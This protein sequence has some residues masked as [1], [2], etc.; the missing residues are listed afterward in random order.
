MSNFA[1]LTIIIIS[2]IYLIISNFLVY[3]VIQLKNKNKN[4]RILLQK[5]KFAKGKNIETTEKSSL[6]SS[7]LDNNNLLTIEYQNAIAILAELAINCLNLQELMQK[8]TEIIANTL[9]IEF[10]Q[11]L[12]LLPNKSAFLLKYGVGWS[13]EIIGFARINNHNNEANYTINNQNPVIMEDLLIETRFK[14]SP[15]LHNYKIVSGVSLTIP[16][17]EEIF[18]MLAVYSLQKR[19]FNS[20]EINFLEHINKIL[21]ATIKRYEEQEKLF[22]LERAIDTSNSGILIS[23]AND[24]QNKIIYVNSGFKKITGYSKKEILGKNCNFLQLEDKK[25]PQISE[26]K[27]AILEG[28]EIETILRNYRKDGTMFW[29]KLHIAPV[30]NSE[31]ILTHFIGIQTDISAQINAELKLKEKNRIL[32]TFT[33]NLQS[34]NHI[35]LTNSETEYILDNFL[36]KGCEI[37]GM[38]TGII[39]EVINDTYLIHSC[40]S[41]HDNNVFPA[42]E[43]KLK[44]TFCYDVI[45]QKRTIGY[46]NISGNFKINPPLFSVDFQ[47][48]S[49]LGT[50]IFIKNKIY[51]TL[52]FFSTFPQKEIPSYQYELIEV[53]A[54]FIEYTIHT[55]EIELEKEQINNALQENQERLDSIFI[56]LEDVI[57]SLHLETL[58]VLYIN[59]TAEKLYECGLINFYNQRCYWLKVIHPE[60]EEWVKESYATLLNIS[61]FNSN[62]NNHDLEYRILLPNGE[63]KYVRDRAHIVYDLNKKPIR[64]DGIITE[65]TNRKKAQNALQKSEEQFRLTFQLAPIGMIITSLDGYI[66]EVNQ[67][68]CDSLKYHSSELI[69]KNYSWFIHPDDLTSD[70]LLKQKILSGEINTYEQEKRYL[71]KDGTI[72]YGIL[73][74]TV[75]QDSNQQPKQFIKQILDISERKKVEDQLLHDALYDKLTG[76]A[77]RILFIDRLNQSLNRYQT[78]NNKFCAVLFLDLDQFKRTNESLGH[79][80]GDQL[81][82]V[83]AQKIKTCL[84]PN[85]TLARLGGDEFSILLNDLK[86]QSE[87]IEIAEQI[88]IVCRSPFLIQGY[89]IFSSV[90]I[91]IAFSSL[92]YNN[93]ED[94]LRDADL[95]MY[96]AKNL[97][98]NCYHIFDKNMHSSL[99]KR[100]EI[101]SLLRKAIE[102][103]EFTLYY[104][105]IICLST[106]KLVGFEALIRWITSDNKFISPADFI[107]ITEE[108]G[109]IIPLGEWI[110][111]QATKQSV[112]W[113]KMFKDLP[114]TISIN[115]SGKQLSQPD[116]LEIIDKILETT[117]ANPRRLKVEVTETIMMDNFLYARQV[118]K[119]IQARNLKI[120]LD[121]FGTGYSSLSY[122]HRLPIDTLKIDRSFVT[123]IN[124]NPEKSAIVNAIITLAHNLSLD[125]IAEGIETE[126]QAEVLKN[127]HCNYGQGYLYSKPINAQDAELFIKQNISS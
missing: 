31:K 88:L 106:N 15:L 20:H 7:N 70:F 52:N 87:A 118:L 30:Y 124:D 109:L 100:V 98:R 96:Q 16:K 13:K 89:E 9:K 94:M 104:Q 73:K 5:Y 81:L 97:G 117:Q 82:I 29:N 79:K 3:K 23:D 41:F 54:Q 21:T 56:S 99:L 66:E 68:F 8:T 95:T 37:F 46:P 119:E 75:L 1:L 12:E 40:Y 77:N 127:L 35:S 57:W 115:L 42:T 76:L 74:V 18:G 59:P 50:P 51:G 48:E 63:E 110:F 65:V 6:Q 83:I 47:V 25:Q 69:N 92:G 113:E 80:F 19:Q 32:E 34:I 72:V 26:I 58:Q 24:S 11:I 105:P 45:E 116:L 78:Y 55:S 64:V 120:S 102:R 14:I 4:L 91:G 90:S 39:S 86:S 103:E 112:I 2:I 85:D 49:Y 111:L 38:E 114:L 44:H 27:K 126:T 101:E 107:P 33:Q 122:L 121:D 60:D 10:S 71:S 67:A 93:A 22:L 43:Y 17:K 61:L 62:N 28:R 123:P 84:R 108:T 53:M 36:K 125:V